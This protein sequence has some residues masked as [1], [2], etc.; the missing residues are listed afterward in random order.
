[1]WVD[2]IFNKYLKFSATYKKIYVVPNHKLS[3][4]FYKSKGFL[5]ALRERLV[6]KFRY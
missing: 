1:M 4:S 2:I 5:K 3:Y 6:D